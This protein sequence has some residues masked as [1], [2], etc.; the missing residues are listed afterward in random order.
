MSSF[1]HLF[2]FYAFNP[3]PSLFTIVTYPKKLPNIPRY[4][5]KIVIAKHS[6]NCKEIHQKT[7]SKYETKVSFDVGTI[8]I[9]SLHAVDIYYAISKLLS[10]I[11]RQSLAIPIFRQTTRI[12]LMYLC[13]CFRMEMDSF[14]QKILER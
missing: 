10:L 5:Y 4:L 7:V 2:T 3:F 14:Q 11:N 13:V 6:N 9:S 12:C 8:T 1:S